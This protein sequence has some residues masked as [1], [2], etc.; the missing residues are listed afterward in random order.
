MENNKL[1]KSVKFLLAVLL[2]WNIFLTYSIFNDSQDNQFLNGDKE[3]AI[4]KHTSTYST[5]DLTKAAEKSSK[6]AVGI[7]TATSEGSGVIYRS[8]KL[9]NGNTKITIITNNHVIAGSSELL[10][11]FANEQEVK[12]DVVGTDVFTDLAVVTVETDFAVDA[13]SIGDSSTIKVGE[14]VLAIGSPLGFD[15]Y[16]SVSEG[17]ISGKDRRVG[18]DLTGDGNEDWDMLVL[19]TTAAINPGNSGGPLINLNGD[20]VG[21]NSMK[22][23][24]YNVEGMGF[25]IP[26][27]EVIPIVNQLIETGE[28][29]RPL[30][31]I[32]GRGIGEY[33]SVHKSYLGL[34]LDIEGGVVVI[35]VLK[36]GAA[37][38]AGIQPNDIIVEFNGVEIN[39]FK[40]F[41]VELYKMKTGDEVQLK[42][43]RGQKF[44]DVSVILK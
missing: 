37:K 16:G 35:E 2:F 29:K 13:F 22:I 38:E 21:I 32:S 3:S 4:I 31:G 25:A 33:S 18:V 27:N 8:E 23:I 41:R 1:N 26:I 9:E 6:K 42:I 19:Q 43:L 24:N 20:L 40:D 36:D 14:W 17:V 12:G 39:T 30:L 7:K 11:L 15:F 28:V 10:V 34:P 44:V 5:T